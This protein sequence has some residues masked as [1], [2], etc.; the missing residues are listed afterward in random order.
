[1]EVLESIFGFLE[2]ASRIKKRW[3]F[4]LHIHFGLMIWITA[5]FDMSLD[6]NS[7][8]L[9]TQVSIVTSSSAVACW[10]LPTV[11]SPISLGTWNIL[12]RQMLAS[13]KRSSQ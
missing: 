2:P 10:R 13:N 5:L 1:V 9:H 3:I 6:Y 4:Y 7:Q 11:E 12:V 8:V